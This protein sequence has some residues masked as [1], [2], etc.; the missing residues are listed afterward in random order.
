LDGRGAVEAGHRQIF[1]TV[2][3]GS[4]LRISLRNVRFVRPDVAIV[5]S[6]ARLTFYEGNETRELETRPTLILVKQQGAWQ[7]VTF[8]NTRIAEMPREAAANRLA[9]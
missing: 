5:F 4:R 7:V 2:Y 6:H 8:Q 9:T 1:D 3:K